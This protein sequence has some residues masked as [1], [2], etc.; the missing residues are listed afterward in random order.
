MNGGGR[1]GGERHRGRRR[2]RG[3]G[4]VAAGRPRF[5]INTTERIPSGSSLLRVVSVTSVVL[6]LATGHQA[7]GTGSEFYFPP[8]SEQVDEKFIKK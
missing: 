7:N 3:G 4:H 5:Y 2:R 8:V 1:R 6:E